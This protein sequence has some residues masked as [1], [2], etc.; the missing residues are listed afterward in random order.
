MIEFS[1]NECQR[2]QM[3]ESDGKLMLSL[4]GRGTTVPGAIAAE[5]LQDALNN[6][7]TG[8][9]KQSQRY[10]DE[11]K[12]ADKNEEDIVSL[13]ARAY[14]LIELLKDA[15]KKKQALVWTQG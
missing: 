2:V 12:E 15:K 11:Q 1:A 13:S 7:Q 14:S 10:E 5:D 4:M 9:P 3:L 6:L 8:I